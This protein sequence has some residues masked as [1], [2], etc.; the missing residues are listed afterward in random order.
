MTLEEERAFLAPFLEQAAGG[1]I[2]VVGQ[3][4]AALDKQLGCEVA[5]AWA[6]NLLHRHG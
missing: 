1:G 5:L 2:F 3:I 4:K 6:Y